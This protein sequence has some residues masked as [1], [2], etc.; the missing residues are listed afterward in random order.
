MGLDSPVLPPPAI[1]RGLRLCTLGALRLEGAEAAA[2]SSRRKELILLAYLARRAG[3]PVARAELAALLWETRD[4]SKARQSLRQALLELRRAVGEGLEVEADQATL[5]EGALEWDGAAFEREVAANRWADALRRW[6]GEFL[7]GDDHLGGETFR[8]WL[9]GEREALRRQLG[10]ALARLVEEAV[11]RG[12]RSDA[13]R[14][15]ERW[16]ELLPADERGHF[17]LIETLHLDGRTGDALARYEGY[18]ARLRAELQLE[19]SA[20]LLRLGER[21]GR[22][23]GRTSPH[24]IA[25][26]VVFTP[27]LVGRDD[28]FQLLATAWA[29]VRGGE[30]GCAVVHG[31]GG[32][33][34][35]RLC[36]DFLRWL[37]ARP[38]RL[39]VLRARAHEAEQDLGWR[40]ARE[41]LSDLPH[42]PG[43]SAAPEQVLAAFAGLVP[44]M[45]ER[46][47]RL[48]E[49]RVSEAELEDAVRR[50]LEDVA[51]EAPIAAFLDDAPVADQQTRRLV[52]SLL[53]HP[54]A[55]VLLLLTGRT[56]DWEQL[57]SAAELQGLPAVRQVRL[58]SLDR[59][60]IEAL[61]AS[62]LELRPADRQELAARLHAESGG[63]PFYAIELLRVLL[64]DGRLEADSAGIWRLSPG[65]A[66]RELPLPITVRDVVSRR[67][68]RLSPAACRALDAAAVLGIPFDLELLAEVAELS[69]TGTEAALGE[70]ILH[71]LLHETDAVAGRFEFAHDLVR[72]HVYQSVPAEQS[73]ALSRR[74]AA[75]LERWAASDA[76]ARTA[77]AR[78]RARIAGHAVAEHGRLR[79]LSVSGL[80]A[81]VVGIGLALA[82]R[83]TPPPTSPTTVAVLPF[84]VRGSPELAYLGEAMATLMSAKLQGAGGLR[85][86]DVRAVLGLSAQQGGA[87]DPASGHRIARRLGA[88]TYLVG[89]LVEAGGRLHLEAAAY[90][91]GETSRPLGQASVEGS[92][93]QLLELVDSLAADLLPALSRGSHQQLTRLAA[94][95]TGSLPALKAY[96]EGERLFREGRFGAAVE[97]FQQAV[98][99]D[100]TF[101]LAHY[102]LSVTAWWNDRPELTTRAAESALRHGARLS[103]RDRRLLRAWDAFLRGDALEAERLYTAILGREPENVEGW[104][105]LGEVLFHSAPRQGFPVSASRQAFERVL[106]FEPEHLSALLHLARIAASERRQ[107]ELDSLAG[108]ILA[109]EPE[110][111]WAQ[112]VRAVHAFALRDS[113]EE[114]RVL[115]DLESATDGRVW[116]AAQYVAVSARNLDGARRLFRLLAQPTRAPEVRAYAHVALA[117]L[118]LA[119]GRLRTTIAELDRAVALDSAS[120]LPYRALLAALPFI[121]SSGTD[122]GQVRNALER[123]A[124]DTGLSPGASHLVAVVEGLHPA[125][126]LY[127]LATLS[128]RRGDGS[129]ARRYLRS[130]EQTNPTIAAKAFADDA[131]ASVRAQLAWHAGDHATALLRLEELLRLEGRL[132]G[133]SAFF[134]RGYERYL[135]AQVHEALGQREEALR[136]YNGFSNELFDLIYVAP[137]RLR[138]AEIARG[139]GRPEEAAEHYRR[140]AELWEGADSELRSLLDATGKSGGETGARENP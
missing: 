33:G 138:R 20:E 16:T 32:I 1:D 41:L 83:P 6:G 77:L 137:S 10:F 87:S 18:V 107:A 72:R 63:N 121:P 14:W 37:E 29:S 140:A 11:G 139:L 70:L 42:A 23:A 81:L 104:T 39:V 105:Q 78:H 90:G 67:L 71:R 82:L 58:R 115:S 17:R 21:I 65:L 92:L 135:Y 89:A 52:V 44:A 61:L 3:R 4:E 19:P 118:A 75:A 126:R 43:A 108:R 45:R 128:V 13:I 133:G 88:G 79:W 25:S 34:K 117:H 102:R 30:P 131:A 56:D 27:D 101:A 15:A 7:A 24:E 97:A 119:E 69:P 57:V 93:D 28:A 129:A 96:L 94:A 132:V 127:L 99:E 64:E 47:P 76:P 68:N 80:A 31:E 36:H 2:L 59:G 49:S 66:E 116:S 114:R 38:E 46:F 120:G 123:W 74:A 8:G 85:S 73:E 136:L 112:E 98:A 35:T 53:R 62:A 134:S 54:P 111:E 26:A 103:D 91:G 124:P 5:G 113:V 9:E 55:G 22:A 60:E 84:S 122:L 12:A 48:P 106:W 86:A 130:L 40:A 51:A 95:T 110:G 100:S 50:L 125:I 109:L